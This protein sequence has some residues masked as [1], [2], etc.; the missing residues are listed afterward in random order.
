MLQPLLILVSAWML[1]STMES[2][3]T[4]ELIAGIAGEHAPLWLF[5]TLIFIVG[6]LISFGTGTS[7]GTIGMLMP[8]A[9]PAVGLHPAFALEANPDIY[10]TLAIAAVFSGAVFGDH[11]SPISDTTIVTSIACG[12]EPYEHVK[13]Q[14]PF[15]L[16]AAAITIVCG[17]L[18]AALGVSPLLCL[19]VT[20]VGLWLWGKRGMRDT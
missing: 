8:L 17:F 16:I 7:W 12:V 11:C 6:A 10:F 14:L 19:A 3:G 2:L 18:P 9:I 1:G 4:A 20:A 13:T 15:A 5:P